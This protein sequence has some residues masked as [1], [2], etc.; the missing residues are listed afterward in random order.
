MLHCSVSSQI[1]NDKLTFLEII[2]LACSVTHGLEVL[3]LNVIH[4]AWLPDRKLKPDLEKCGLRKVIFKRKLKVNWVLINWSKNADVSPIFQIILRLL[5]YT[6]KDTSLH[7][8]FSS[9]HSIHWKKLWIF[10]YRFAQ[11]SFC[12][13]F[14]TA[15][16]TS[17]NSDSFPNFL[18]S[19]ESWELVWYSSAGHV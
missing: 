16:R 6:K 12:N 2:Y 18:E 15:L 19:S 11:R 14:I 1:I 5:W 13:F 7:S 9:V 17:I 8:A 10:R 4:S 3:L